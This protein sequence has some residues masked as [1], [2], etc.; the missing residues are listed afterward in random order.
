MQFIDQSDRY[1]RKALSVRQ[2]LREFR[3]R[4][5]AGAGAGKLMDSFTPELEAAN[6]FDR[7]IAARMNFNAL[8][9][10]VSHVVS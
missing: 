8:P 3:A 7:S 2:A 4:V 5:G 10:V 6:A 1:D 9:T